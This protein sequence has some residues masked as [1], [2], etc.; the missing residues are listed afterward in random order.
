MGDSLARAT[1]AVYR[2]AW[3]QGIYAA[4]VLGSAYIGKHW[5]ISG[6]VIGVLCALTANFILMAHLSLSL[7]SMRL[8][9]YLATHMPAIA[10]STIVLFEVLISAKVMRNFLIPQITILVVSAILIFFTVAMLFYL[11]PKLFLG[12]DGIWMCQT[13][14]DY[15]PEKFKIAQWP[16]N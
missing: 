14:A 13:L 1:G 12:R 10:L 7:T 8:R 16:N 6:V 3:R 15:L 4:F 11:M 9:T 2:R 5:G